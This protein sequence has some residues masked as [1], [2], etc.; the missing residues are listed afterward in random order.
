MTG[1]FDSVDALLAQARRSIDRHAPADAAR[2]VAEGA[3]LVDIRP[4]WQ[5][6]EDGEIPG[7]LV[8]ER[9]HLEWR[10]HPDSG[11]ALPQAARDQSWIVYCTEGY[12]SSLAAATLVSLGL[13]AGDLDGGIRA[14]RA[15]GLP[16]VAGGTPVE[17]VVGA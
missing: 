17:G 15:A 7:A 11:A 4:A 8:V 2:R 16:I 14:W 10:L 6:V 5:R 12:S 1:S 13:R 3:L 9:N